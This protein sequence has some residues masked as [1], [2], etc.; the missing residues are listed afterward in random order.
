MRHYANMR[1]AQLTLYFALTAG[2]MSSVFMAD[3]ALPAPLRQVLKLL[4]AVAGCAFGLME[5]R[6]ADYWHHF[7]K[8]AEALEKTL[9]YAQYSNRPE[10]KVLSATNAT[11]LLIWGS[12]LLWLA[13]A[14]WCSF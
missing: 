6:A 8:R 3:P 13:S 7:R 2:L 11:R 10:A 5:E 14:I 9:G 12:V 1:F 4:G